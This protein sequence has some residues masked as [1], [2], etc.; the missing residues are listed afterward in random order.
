MDGVLNIAYNPVK[1]QY[2]I[3]E[4]IAVLVISGQNQTKSTTNSKQKKVKKLARKGS[5]NNLTID[6]DQNGSSRS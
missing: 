1:K 2:F 5:F 3:N 4:N 6:F